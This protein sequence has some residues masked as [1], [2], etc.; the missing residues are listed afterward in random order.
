MPTL[1][2]HKIFYEIYLR[3]RMKLDTLKSNNRLV[4]R[5]LFT[6]FRS[7]QSGKSCPHPGHDNLPNHVVTTFIP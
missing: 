6:T 7:F 3:R 1:C 5:V 4:P 2:L